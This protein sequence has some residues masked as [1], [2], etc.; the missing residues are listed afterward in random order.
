M[1]R[2]IG[3][4]DSPHS[5]DAH[6]S[7][8]T[9]NEVAPPFQPEN[10]E[11]SVHELKQKL[12]QG[13]SILLLD[14]REPAEYEIARFEDALLIPLKE[15]PQQVNRLHPDREIVI[16][17]HAGVRSMYAA[18]YLYQIGFRNVK[19][20]AGGIDQWAIEIDPTLNRY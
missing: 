12:D 13:D 18:S 4:S 16:H 7:S 11:I 3:D 10:H 8:T 20:L 2:P 17:C 15:L 9:T 5:A 19:S 1:K 14:V 6:P